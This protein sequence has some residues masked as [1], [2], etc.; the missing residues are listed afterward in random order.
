MKDN[1][2]RILA[3]GV[4]LAALV[5]LHL[6]A[7]STALRLTLV[8]GAVFCWRTGRPWLLIVALVGLTSLQAGAAWAELSEPVVPG[9]FAGTAQLTTDPQPTVGGV[10]ARAR[11]DDRVYDLRAWG[12]PAGWLR[13]RL[14]GE[15]IEIQASLRPIVDAPVWLRAQGVAGRGTVTNASGFTEGAMH[16]RIANSLRRTIESGAASMSRSE[17]ALFTGLVYGDDRQQSP[18]VADNFAGAGLTHLLAVSGQNVVFVLAIAG[19]ML[20]RLGHRRR[21]A[22]VLAL[23]MLF[24]TMTRFE[25]SVIRAAVMTSIAATGALVGT[26]VSATRVLLLAIVG[27]LV[28]HP[29]LV[30]SVAFQLSLA[31]SA[32]ILLWSARVARAIP[33][34]RPLIEALAVTAT[35]QL[36][37]APLLLWRFDGL[38]VASLPANLLA[39]PAAG[40]IMMWGMT[41]GW[42]AGLAPAWV[43]AVIHLPTRAGLWWIDG[44]AQWTAS[45]PMGELGWLHLIVLAGAGWT[46]LRSERSWTRRCALVTVVTALV[47]PGVMG[48][49]AGPAGARSLG[50]GA[51]LWQDDVATVVEI[52]GADRPEDVLAGLRR[53]GVSQIDVLIAGRSSFQMR[54]LVRWVDDRHGVGTV[55]AWDTSMG[56][57][58]S[59]PEPGSALHIA[60]RRCRVKT[61]ERALR[62]DCE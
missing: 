24:A 17:R 54:D 22:V 6:S 51:R 23:L 5:P 27:L 59:V 36:A 33:G 44:V 7:W 30:H 39:G 21:F 48:A 49:L 31:A 10:R 42:V 40:P 41:A 45:K 57:G 46:G 47:M 16:T 9:S 15:Q 1:Q 35:A 62:L 8:I 38:P 32:G 19:P 14:M 26:A 11:I 43:S 60:G 56:V 61:D 52:A 58:E 13:G 20:R 29:L 34:P 37:V 55:W 50:S 28:V 12:S 3:A 4:A 2:I 25:P 18:L 53:A